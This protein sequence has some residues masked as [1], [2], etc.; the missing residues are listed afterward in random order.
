MKRLR[1]N[2]PPDSLRARFLNFPG[3][4]PYKA[5]LD[6]NGNQQDPYRKYV[7]LGALGLRQLDAESVLKTDTG[8]AFGGFSY[9]YLQQCEPVS[10]S[11]KPASIAVPDIF[12][13]APEIV[14]YQEQVSGAVY[15]EAEDPQRFM[16]LL[17]GTTPI[18]EDRLQPTSSV[19]CKMSRADYV[20][21]IRR[22]QNQIR[23]GWVYEANLSR[24]LHFTASCPRPESLCDSWFRNSPVP[25]SAYYQWDNLFIW[26]G[27]PERFLARRGNTLI[28]QPIK[29]TAPRLTE[30]VADQETGT[31]LQIS[32]KN[33]AENIMIVDLVRNDLNRVCIPGTVVVPELCGLHSFTWVHHLISTIQ[34]ELRAGC[35]SFEA[36][37][38]AFPP[39]SMTGAPKVSAMNLI[40]ELEPEGR[41]LFAG[42]LGYFDPEGDFDFNVVIRTLIGDRQTGK[43][44]YHAGGAVTIDSDPD[45]EYE[46]T[47]VKSR[48]LLRWL[49]Q[50]SHS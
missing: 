21:A 34:G 45:E 42:S 33:R 13:F 38:S 24:C 28:S 8:W 17:E 20:E 11:L 47:E 22:L 46:E 14:I 7:F 29:G 3:T 40:H 25:F 26:C 31:A 50:V 41:G 16:Q 9:P 48:N 39:G 6:S 32:E 1:W 35:T 23:E 43:F 5:W 44:S 10:A 12:F 27:S 30:P 36:L 37:K 2:N 18:S 19:Q 4:W 15:V 49:E